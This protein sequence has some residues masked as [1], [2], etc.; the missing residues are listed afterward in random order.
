[1]KTIKALILVSLFSSSLYADTLPLVKLG[2]C[3][4]LRDIEFEYDQND[5]EV[6]IKQVTSIQC[7][8]TSRQCQQQQLL[9][10]KIRRDDFADSLE[11]EKRFNRFLRI[12]NLIRQEILAGTLNYEYI[13]LNPGEEFI[14]GSKA[15]LCH[16][17]W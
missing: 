12:Q 16:R 17:E 6:G 15:I 8:N 10:S 11:G 13:G 9:H 7:L 14:Y 1:M 2:E 5:N 4:S 3:I